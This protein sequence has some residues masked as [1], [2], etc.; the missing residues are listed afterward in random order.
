[1]L[2][3]AILVLGAA[4]VLGL[5]VVAFGYALPVDHVASGERI[6]SQAPAGIF[7]IIMDVERYPT[8]RSDVEAVQ[9]LERTPHLRW[10]ERGPN[11]EITFEL[12]DSVP[13]SRIV[14]K[15]A[16]RTLPFG[17]SWMFVLTP[18]AGGARVVI[19]EHGEVYTPLFRV[20]SRFVFGHTATIETFL[21]DLAARASTPA[22]R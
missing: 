2:R 15:I 18:E 10:R 21:G 13:A 19:T 1:M 5:A 11:G 12:Q 7:A 3:K 4:A 6:V 22:G 17:G 9:V 20:M 14:T 16:D 8:W